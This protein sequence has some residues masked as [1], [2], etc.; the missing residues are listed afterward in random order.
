MLMR[1]FLIFLAGLPLLADTSHVASSNYWPLDGRLTLT[2]TM[3]DGRE[4]TH[5]K[6]GKDEHGTAFDSW[7]FMSGGYGKIWVAEVS[8]ELRLTRMEFPNWSVITVKPGIAFLK[9]PAYV[10]RQWDQEAELE[11]ATIGWKIK[12]KIKSKV[13]AREKVRVTAGEFVC[14]VVDATWESNGEGIHLISEERL[15]YAAGVGIVKH[16]MTMN[17][18]GFVSHVAAELSKIERH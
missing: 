12:T 7:R 9:F 16:K 3:N 8:G 4:L 6:T 2:Y 15:W 18:N 11:Y 17:Q 14:L 10:G 5:R 13:L 1:A